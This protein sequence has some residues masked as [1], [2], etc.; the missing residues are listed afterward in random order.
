MNLAT[1]IAL[2][3]VIARELGE[4]LYYPGSQ[5]LYMGYDSFTS[6]DLYASELN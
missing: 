2:Y 3:A 4:D 6:S 1:A 5:D